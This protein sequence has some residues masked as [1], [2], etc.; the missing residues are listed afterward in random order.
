[1]HY[2][3]DRIIRLE[4]NYIETLFERYLPTFFMP[5]MLVGS[6]Y[7]EHFRSEN[8]T[9]NNIQITLT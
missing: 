4:K 5:Q 6:L 9:N 3:T 1:M 8:F 2:Y 7:E